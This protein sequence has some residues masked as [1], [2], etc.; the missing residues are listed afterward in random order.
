[1]KIKTFGE[2]VKQVKTLFSALGIAYW[3]VY[4]TELGRYT[5]WPNTY[6]SEN[7]NVKPYPGLMYKIE[8]SLIVSDPVELF[9]IQEDFLFS[10]A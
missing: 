4:I 8:T 10:I 5:D 6:H 1:M 3:S 7:S 9:I 2:A